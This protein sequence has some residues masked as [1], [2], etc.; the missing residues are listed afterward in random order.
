MKQEL[1][2]RQDEPEEGAQMA[3]GLGFIDLRG[4][5]GFGPRQRLIL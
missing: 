3:M 4:L 2:L 1:C 5:A